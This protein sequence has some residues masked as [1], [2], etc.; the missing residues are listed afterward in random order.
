MIALTPAQH[1]ALSMLV[2]TLDA[3]TIPYQIT[4]GLAGNFHGSLWPLHDLDLEV[5]TPLATVAAS[6]SKPSAAAPTPF[7]TSDF[8]PAPLTPRDNIQ[9]RTH[10]H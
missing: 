9:G 2:T 3:H 7:V 10:G 6:L 1:G 8:L 4:G 5:D